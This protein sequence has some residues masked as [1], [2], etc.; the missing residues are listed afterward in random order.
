MERVLQMLLTGLLFIALHAP[1]SEDDIQYYIVPNSST[2]D[3]IH[4]QSCLTFDYF[5]RTCRY[6]RDNFTL[7]FL[8]GYHK[9]PRL[10]LYYPRI[11]YYAYMDNL[12]MIGTNTDVIINDMD[13][14]FINAQE[15]Q[16]KNLTLTNGI[17]HIYMA[18]GATLLRLF[19]V[20]LI[21]HIFYI[22]NAALAHLSDCKFTNGSSPLT[23]HTSRVTLSG[24][25]TFFNNYNSA[26]VSYISAIVL[27]GTIS[28]VNNSGIRGGAM[29]LYSSTIQVINGLNVSFINNTAHETGGGIH[30]EPDMTRNACP[31]CLY[32]INDYYQE[33]E[34]YLTGTNIEITFYYSGNSA[35]L[36]GDNI[37]GTS[38]ALCEQFNQPN[39]H[40]H[41]YFSSNA[42]ISSVS[43][44]PIQVCLCNSDHQLLCKNI[45]QTLTSKS[46]YPGETFMIPAVLVGGDYGTTTGTVHASFMSTNLSSV[47]GLES[48]HQYS[49]WIDN[50][51]VC[52]DLQYSIY[53]K[54]VGKN[55]TMYL[56]VQ[57]S[58][59][60]S[61]HVEVI[62]HDDERC[63]Y[64]NLRY[65]SSA[66]TYINLTILP[67][68]TG[69][70]LQEQTLT[71]NCHSILWYNGVKC[72]IINGKSYFSWN[73]TLWINITNTEFTHVK[74]CPLHYCDPAGKQI[75]LERD[76]SAQ[77]AFNRAGRLCGGCREG[78]SLAIGSSNC[79]HC[80]N[81]NGLALLIFFA[82][83]G[84]L[85]VFFINVLDITLTQGLLDG[86]IFYANIVW[87]YQSV[88]F[89]E[90][91]NFNGTT[92]FLK[93]FIAWLNL[94]FG[95]ETC[96][97]KGLTSVWKTWLQFVFPFY[98]WAI[99]GMMIFTAR[100]SRILTKL[101]GNRAVPV[102][103]T[104]FLL[105]YMKLLRTITSIFML[106]H[107][108]QYPKK[109]T[110]S[111]WSVDGNIDYFGLPHS[112]LLVAA[113]I[114]Q[115]FL[116]LPYTLV[117]LLHQQLQKYSHIRIF[118]WVTNLKPFFD[119]H[120]APFKPAH[121]YWFGVLLLARGILL[122]IFSSSFATPKNTNLLLLLILVLALLLYMA[123]VQPYRN[124][125]IFIV[126][127]SF[128]VNLLLLSVF[129]LY[130][131]TH[132]NKYTLQTTIVG[133]STGVTFLQFC[134]IIMINVIRLCCRAKCNSYKNR[135]NLED[136]EELIETFSTNYHTYIMR[137]FF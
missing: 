41:N 44:E 73:S 90:Q 74:Y 17:L 34:F 6:Y 95:I 113:L 70:S 46:V 68:P 101:Y 89:P 80:P 97:V 8:R 58:K 87:T 81:N 57:S 32:Q 124:K 127:S 60:A 56:M 37:Y 88:L 22:K 99:V 78:C 76:P 61:K 39:I 49:Q 47:L 15:L 28:F 120:F 102:L 31:E 13:V 43:S 111:V 83:A 117:L 85:L 5:I 125:A 128:L 109:S 66:P 1:T 134:G 19:S 104:L 69:F 45:P 2:S 51:S 114:V 108:L 131:E 91:S 82:A 9:V 14:R 100:H 93:T 4:N 59:H 42:S 50:T 24:H 96:F 11:T 98:I 130:A 77:C 92:I 35:H 123:T 3:C 55:F 7:F 62:R 135:A 38:L 64:K 118:N 48:N 72:K 25:S 112:L 23:I 10:G 136:E 12:T 79:I 16:L 122:A 116:W 36:G 121:R 115:V 27:S 110:V 71:C 63:E 40:I 126:Q 132:E 33:I 26:F 107:I 86:L 119:V 65:V 137:A 84:L 75:E 67:C 29:A 129:I 53:S 21:N 30:T 20:T 94:D 54:N 103:A 106:S 133:I 105:S 18:Q 52:T